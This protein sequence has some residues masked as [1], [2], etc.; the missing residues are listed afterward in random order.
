MTNKYKKE[1]EDINR[2]VYGNMRIKRL[3]DIAKGKHGLLNVD[4]Y[5]KANKNELVERLVKGKQLED[6]NKNTILKYGQDQGL[7]L[8]ASS[9]KK[10]LIEKI[11]NPKLEDLNNKRLRNLADKGGVPLRSQMTDGQIIQRLRNPDAYYNKTSLGRLARNNNIEFPRNI[12]L[13][14]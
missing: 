4:H 1:I 7:K 8:N 9:S 3:K 13:Q 6:E 5:T 14:E 2:R 11:R 10:T 12:S